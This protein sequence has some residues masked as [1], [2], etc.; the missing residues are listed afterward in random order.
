[1]Y[2][3]RNSAQKK[4]LIDN[5]FPY[6]YTAISLYEAALEL[7][8]LGWARNILKP[9]LTL[10]MVTIFYVK[11]KEVQSE[12]RRYIYL[13]LIATFLAESISTF[14]QPEKG[15]SIPYLIVNAISYFLFAYAF[16]TN[17]ME[18]QIST[19]LPLVLAFALPYIL[20]SLI[21]Y[22]FLKEH[23]YNAKWAVIVN[24]IFLVLMGIQSAVRNHNTIGKSFMSTALGGAG[25]FLSDCIL[26][27]LDAKGSKA[28]FVRALMVLVKSLARYGIVSGSL[29]H[30]QFF[31][32]EKKELLGQSL[33][34][35]AA[36]AKK[37]ERPKE[38]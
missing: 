1:M 12:F 19:G 33:F 9:I 10:T 29:A 37:I 22:L 5:L 26:M 21:A 25:C 14:T 11:T 13:G 28:H 23:V 31:D 24:L 38:Q 4:T 32:V 15:L 36:R 30:I 7:F 2:G 27:V 16:T 6:V 35:P 3:R 18:G 17:I 8:D 34:G 20:F